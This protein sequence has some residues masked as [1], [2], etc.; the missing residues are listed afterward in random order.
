M[1][2]VSWYAEVDNSQLQVV[3][4]LAVLLELHRAGVIDVEDDIEK[5]KLDL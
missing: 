2:P 5:R 1:L 3:N 4:A